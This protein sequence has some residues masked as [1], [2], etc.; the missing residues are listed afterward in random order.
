MSRTEVIGNATLHLGDCREILPALQKMG[1]LITDPPYGILNLA[2]EGST[3]AVR[4][5]PRQQGS[6]A[7]KN[8]ILNRSDV[9]WDVA[10]DVDTL[11]LLMAAAPVQIIWGGNYFPLPPTRAV[12]V[13]DKEQPWEN[14]SQVELAWTNL[15]RPAAIFR[16]SATRGTP[17]K[18]HPTQKP[19]SLMRWCVALAKGSDSILDPYMGSGTT[20][21]AAVEAG[22]KFVGCEVDPAYFDIACRRIDDAQRQGRLIA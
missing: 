22:R 7:L 20:G 9:R 8:R 14:F 16:E 1:A 4:K 18:E 11:A 19:L 17:G 12:L 13:W 3:P 6:G 15:G 2:G 10:P 21:V 5:S